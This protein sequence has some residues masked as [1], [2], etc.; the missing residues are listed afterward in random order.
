MKQ[1]EPTTTYAADTTRWTKSWVISNYHHCS[2]WLD[3]VWFEAESIEASPASMGLMDHTVSPVGRGYKAIVSSQ[4]NS[5]VV[6]Y[7]V[8]IPVIFMVLLFISLNDIM[9]K[10]LSEPSIIG[11]HLQTQT[12]H[13]EWKIPE[14]RK[15]S[16]QDYRQEGWL[17][18]ASWSPCISGNDLK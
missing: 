15:G 14:W 6:S 13:E 9:L 8:I 4:N 17:I 7:T 11:F 5:P 12:L 16:E 3:C 1:H 18:S 2:G 10:S